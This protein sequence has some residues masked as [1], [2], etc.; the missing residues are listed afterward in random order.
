MLLPLS[1]PVPLLPGTAARVEQVRQGAE[2]PPPARF[3]HFHGPAE[4]VLIEEG[5]GHFLCEDRRLPFAPGTLLY[6]PP[7]TIHD[8]DFAEGARGWTLIQFDPHAVS[9]EGASLPV[10]PHAIALESSGLA[11]FSMLADWLA[12]AGPTRIVPLQALVLA[13]AQAIGP[14]ES[15]VPATASALARFRPLLDLMDR[16]PGAMLSIPEAATLCAMSPAYF[17]RRFARAF[18]VGFI[19]YQTRLKL[20]RAARFLATTSELVSQ[21]AY[22]LGFRSHAYFSHCFRAEFGAPPS[23]YRRR[24]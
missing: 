24:R 18:G 10:R 6:A 2:C 22:G 1:E 4:L 5:T 21:I 16:E 12:E 8:F 17:S 20:Q 19:A 3:L 13:A 9:R 7:M 11:R 14:D 15:T 23:S